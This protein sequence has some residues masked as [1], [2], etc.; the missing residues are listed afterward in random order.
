[1]LNA[2]GIKS[3]RGGIREKLL[4]EKGG[5]TFL[6]QLPHPNQ[7]GLPHELLSLLLKLVNLLSGQPLLLP[8]LQVLWLNA[9]L[10]IQPLI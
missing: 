5:G 6:W 3:P 1:M 10:V 7:S 2:K 4:Q 9:R 8:H